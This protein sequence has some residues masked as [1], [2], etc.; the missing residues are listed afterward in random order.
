[1]MIYSPEDKGIYDSIVSEFK[2]NNSNIEKMEELI[3]NLINSR[4]DICKLFKMKIFKTE[5]L[6][7]NKKELIKNINTNKSSIKEY[8]KEKIEIESKIKANKENIKVIKLCITKLDNKLS[9]EKQEGKKLREALK[10]FLSREKFKF[11]K[12]FIIKKYKTIYLNYSNELSIKIK[13]KQC[14]ERQEK[15]RCEKLDFNK[16]RK[17]VV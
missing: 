10:I 4:K 17:S 14:N 7:E 16:D 6:D 9:K 11:I 5:T 8:E 12:K 1:M 15:I 2:L 13:I 3:I